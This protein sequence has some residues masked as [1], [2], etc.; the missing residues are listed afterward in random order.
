MT[1]RYIVEAR[2][3]VGTLEEADALAGRLA[4][5]VLKG[6]EPGALVA[7]ATLGGPTRFQTNSIALRDDAVRVY[8]DGMRLPS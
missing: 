1:D 4:E 5:D 7:Y 6:N 3:V 2:V 8:P